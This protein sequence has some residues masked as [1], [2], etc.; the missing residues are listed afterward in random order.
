M[1]GGVLEAVSYTHLD[2]YKRQRLLNGAWQTIIPGSLP[3][4]N[5]KGFIIICLDILY[6]I[7]R[8]SNTKEQ[9]RKIYPV[10]SV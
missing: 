10:F 1:S 3:K 7:K 4:E 9:G 2:V 5:T 6:K 8:I